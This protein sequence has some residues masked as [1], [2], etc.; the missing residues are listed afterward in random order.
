MDDADFAIELLKIRGGRMPDQE[1][2]RH[3]REKLDKKWED[4]D[5]KIRHVKFELE[6]LQRKCKHPNKYKVSRMGE[7]AW[8]CPDCRWER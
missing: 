4:I 7:V 2:I 1:Q 5:T 6:E 3:E 8:F